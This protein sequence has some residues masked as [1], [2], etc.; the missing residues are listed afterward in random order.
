M[1][2]WVVLLAIT[3]AIAL[4]AIVPVLARN[5]SKRAS[6]KIA[7]AED[8]ADLEA[9]SWGADDVMVIGR[10][11]DEAAQAWRNAGR[12]LSM[13]T[14]VAAIAR[15]DP[16]MAEVDPD[17][18]LQSRMFWVNSITAGMTRDV[19]QGALPQEGADGHVYG[20][21]FIPKSARLQWP[22]GLIAAPKFVSKS[23]YASQPAGIK[24]IT[25][26]HDGDRLSVIVQLPEGERVATRARWGPI[27]GRSGF[28]ESIYKAGKGIY[29]WT[30]SHYL[31]ND[32]E[33]REKR[34]YPR[35]AT[36]SATL[37]GNFCVVQGWSEQFVKPD[38]QAARHRQKIGYA[39]QGSSFNETLA[40]LTV[41]GVRTCP[42]VDWAAMQGAV[43]QLCFVMPHYEFFWT[44]ATAPSCQRSVNDI[45]TAL[46]ATLGAQSD[47]ARVLLALA[48][49]GGL[50]TAFQAQGYS[51][52][53]FFVV[54]EVGELLVERVTNMMIEKRY[55]PMEVVPQ[56]LPDFSIVNSAVCLD[57]QQRRDLTVL[58]WVSG[59]EHLDTFSEYEVNVLGG[60]HQQ[61][62]DLREARASHKSGN[63]AFT[64][65]AGKSLPEAT[66]WYAAEPIAVSVLTTSRYSHSRAYHPAFVPHHGISVPIGISTTDGLVGGGTSMVRHVDLVI[67]PSEPVG[68]TY[69]IP[70]LIVDGTQ[71]LQRSPSAGLEVARLDG[72]P[73]HDTS[74]GVLCAAVWLQ[75][76]Q[77]P[78][79]SYH[80]GPALRNILGGAVLGGW[81]VMK[82]P[83]ALWDIDDEDA[84]SE[85]GAVAR[86]ARGHGQHMYACFAVIGATDDAGAV[87]TD[88]I[89]RF[90]LLLQSVQK[91]TGTPRWIY[92]PRVLPQVLG[93]DDGTGDRCRWMLELLLGRRYVR[94][95]LQGVDSFSINAAEDPDEGANDVPDET[96]M[97]VP[98]ARRAG[99]RTPWDPVLVG[100]DMLTRT[101]FV[102]EGPAPEDPEQPPDQMV[103]MMDENQVLTIESGTGIAAQ[104]AITIK[105]DWTFQQSGVTF[106]LLKDPLGSYAIESDPDSDDLLL[107]RSPYVNESQN[108][109]LVER[110]Y[111]N[112][113]TSDST[114]ELSAW[115]TGWSAQS[116]RYDFTWDGKGAFIEFDSVDTT[117]AEGWTHAPLAS[118]G[119]KL[120]PP[121]DT[122]YF[123]IEFGTM[124]F[125]TKIWRKGVGY[126]NTMVT[127]YEV[128][129]SE[130][131]AVM[132]LRFAG[133]NVAGELLS[134]RMN[135]KDLTFTWQEVQEGTSY[136]Y[137]IG[138][139][140]MANLTLDPNPDVG[141][142]NI[143]SPLTLVSNTNE[144]S[145]VNQEGTKLLTFDVN[146]DNLTAGEGFDWT[147]VPKAAALKSLA[148][149]YSTGLLESRETSSDSFGTPA[150][151]A[152]GPDATMTAA[153]STMVLGSPLIDVAA[154]A[155]WDM[156]WSDYWDS[157][158]SMDPADPV[159]MRWDTM[160]G[161]TLCTTCTWSWTGWGM[162]TVMRRT[163]E[164]DSIKAVQ[165]AFRVLGY[166]N[167]QIHMNAVTPACTVE[168]ELKSQWFASTL[169][170]EPGVTFWVVDPRTDA[171]QRRTYMRYNSQELSKTKDARKIYRGGEVWDEEAKGSWQEHEAWDSPKSALFD[172]TGW[173][174]QT[175]QGVVL[176]PNS[177]VEPKADEIGCNWVTYA[178]RVHLFQSAPAP[179]DVV[180]GR[181]PVAEML[182]RKPTSMVCS[183]VK[184]S[185]LNT[186][187]GVG[188]G[189]Y[190][191]RHFTSLIDIGAYVSH[192]S[193]DS[194]YPDFDKY[195]KPLRRYQAQLPSTGT[196]EQDRWAY[197]YT[198]YE[199]TMRFAHM[200]WVP[201]MSKLCFAEEK[202][203]DLVMKTSTTLEGGG[204]LWYG[205]NMRWDSKDEQFREFSYSDAI[206]AWNTE[207]GDTYSTTYDSTSMQQALARFGVQSSHKLYLADRA[208]APAVRLTSDWANYL[209]SHASI[210][211]RMNQVTQ[212][213]SDQDPLGQ[214]AT[215]M[216]TTEDTLQP[217][218]FLPQRQ[219]YD[220]VAWRMYVYLGTVTNADTTDNNLRYVFH[221]D[222]ITTDTYLNSPWHELVPSWDARTMTQVRSKLGEVETAWTTPEDVA[223]QLTTTVWTT[224]TINGTRYLAGQFYVPH[225]DWFRGC[226]P[227]WIFD[228][229]R[230]PTVIPGVALIKAYGVP[231]I[232][233]EEKLF[234]SV[235]QYATALLDLLDLIMLPKS[236]FGISKFLKNGFKLMGKL[237]AKKASN[238]VL[239]KVAWY[240]AKKAVKKALSATVTLA[241][242]TK[243]VNSLFDD[244][245]TDYSA[246]QRP[247]T[248]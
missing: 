2:G 40:G 36:V 99:T 43:Q 106:V 123:A 65:L 81:S 103:L 27:A 100:G 149:T 24:P 165:S 158:S 146:G 207:P 20:Y 85:F 136:S 235:V 67:D 93:E 7:A 169:T 145:I 181:V 94:F 244:G 139:F 170:F 64:D 15:R 211:T 87:D 18:S 196:T 45:G 97:R 189:T 55:F 125:S 117:V 209:R 168:T 162:G 208:L 178:D 135:S 96:S 28:S 239:R 11:T 38:G 68:A 223:T 52:M 80:I 42:Q 194:L 83:S 25:A 58:T 71:A 171:H 126:F 160:R 172:Q 226:G 92:P 118:G 110:P 229:L 124:P 78:A 232:V 150:Q 1:V 76:V 73:A 70:G 159:R 62:G 29:I 107:Y 153:V 31:Q 177:N 176:A 219:E 5:V 184:D 222:P 88:I 14:M 72:I 69:T 137:T 220:G 121:G 241:R 152:D 48:H 119:Y 230:Q 248:L 213:V 54:I 91:R 224:T 218:D 242:S 198:R 35:F 112:L 44:N 66:M 82:I 133:R 197:L 234:P 202:P 156:S 53:L 22:F 8:K 13:L 195:W 238:K 204:N 231:G 192:G 187:T 167:K 148:M 233:R 143:I 190:R 9:M 19:L 50:K 180:L 23:F 51:N 90:S 12:T 120:Y 214:L 174:I 210:Y 221:A 115:P 228:L 102:L 128:V 201:Q 212:R 104:T 95:D 215:G 154:H 151:P 30:D 113:F 144:N 131:D 37:P 236:L 59:A 75:S 134:A 142:I 17:L 191:I 116:V 122:S 77:E 163:W 147:V 98:G 205:E 175:S 129:H 179:R 182:R 21:V 183:T 237:I 79:S 57:D 216:I 4:V 105:R 74:G 47:Y 33:W 41:S 155:T 111:L 240:I 166:R 173:K 101:R 34:R 193:G 60:Q 130:T 3:A 186:G 188:I 161:E 109:W 32:G 132:T 203:S 26:L 206:W 89:D 114:G 16:L 243:V 46:R 10:F 200:R 63:L 108:A 225:Q 141:P 157:S 127:T 247:N 6:A 39:E 245:G 61:A 49:T 217:E 84:A 56:Q 164:D 138:A 185:I 246:V 227:F 86:A 199:F 140:F